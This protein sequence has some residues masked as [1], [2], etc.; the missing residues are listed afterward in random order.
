MK[1]TARPVNQAALLE[2]YI[3]RLVSKQPQWMRAMFT[4][5]QVVFCVED[6]MSFVLAFSKDLAATTKERI[7]Q[8]VA[9]YMEKFPCSILQ[10]TVVQ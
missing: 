2:K 7:R 1:N 8:R 9:A 5:E 3:K 4:K 10:E 6:D